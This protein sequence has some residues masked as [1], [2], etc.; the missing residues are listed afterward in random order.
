MKGGPI[1]VTGDSQEK[2]KELLDEFG[3]VLVDQ[4]DQISKKHEKAITTK[5]DEL[6]S[7]ILKNSKIP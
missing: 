7:D 1:E 6:R 3:T 4:I 5:L 2:L